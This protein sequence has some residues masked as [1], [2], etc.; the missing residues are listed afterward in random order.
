MSDSGTNSMPPSAAS[1]TASSTSNTNG[2]LRGSSQPATL[3]GFRTA[4]DMLQSQPPPAADD[5]TPPS[6]AP[7]PARQANEPLTANTPRSTFLIPNIP[8][9]TKYDLKDIQ[10]L[11]IVR[12]SKGKLKHEKR[13]CVLEPIKEIL[14]SQRHPATVTFIT[15]LTLVMADSS[16]LI[17][18]KKSCLDTFLEQERKKDSEN[19]TF[20]P[21]SMRIKTKL[22]F[23]N[24]C[25][26]DAIMAELQEQQT[27]LNKDYMNKSGA[28]CKKVAGRALEV[29]QEMHLE[30]FVKHTINLFEVRLTVYN[31][32]IPSTD[33]PRD[34]RILA[35]KTLIGLIQASPQEGLNDS[36]FTEYLETT[37]ENLTNL[38]LGYGGTTLTDNTPFTQD[39]LKIVVLTL[40]NVL[41]Y[42][43]VVTEGLQKY[44]NQKVLF[45]KAEDEATAHAARIRLRGQT[46]ETAVDLEQEPASTRKDVSGVIQNE[47]SLQVSKE[48]TKKRQKTKD[49]R[50]N[51]SGGSAAQ[52]RA[53]QNG[54]DKSSKSGSKSKEKQAKK[55]QNTST[56]KRVRFQGGANKDGRKGKRKSPQQ[57]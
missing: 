14:Q 57:K 39:E 8:A 19:P 50:K 22:T 33:G 45:R 2:Q 5:T 37:R 9:V 34:V 51:S 26:D 52:K 24:E 28:L 41:P 42:F 47:A 13:E 6:V 55:K 11:Q 17:M 54:K 1:G 49:S 46:A 18:H 15:T 40:E 20:V 7:A 44:L 16:F 25:K 43:T 12:D 35:K 21:R 4:A 30:L 29:F 27:A 48:L 23:P 38:V 56:K 3:Q 53:T 31:G 10:N 36:F 32:T